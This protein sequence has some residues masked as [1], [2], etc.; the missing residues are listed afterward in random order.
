MIVDRIETLEAFD[1]IRDAYEDVYARD[2]HRNVFLSWAWLRAFM[3][4][5]RL[6]WTMLCVRRGTSYVAFCLVVERGMRIGPARLYRELALGAYPTA[7]YCGVLVG[8][9]EEAAICALATAIDDLRWNL[10]R[11]ADV[12]DPRVKRLI[13]LLG[14]GNAISTPAPT[15]A[16][17]VPLP[18]TWHEYVERGRSSRQSLRYVLRRYRQWQDAGFV[19]SDDRTIDRDIETLLELNHRRWK[20]NLRK[21]RK[22]YGRLFREAYANG[23]CTVAV[24]RAG[25]RPIAAQAAFVD[26]EQ[27]SW[28]V[29][30]LACDRNAPRNSPG[31]GM[32]A[33][34][35]ERA[36]ERRF[37]EY[38]FLRGSEAFKSQFGAQ[39]R[40]LDNYVVRRRTF[41]S[42]VGEFLYTFALQAKSRV[43]ALVVGGVA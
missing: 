4:A 21:A 6:P 41:W 39:V 8:D 3:L 16:S 5:M 13:T 34:A 29:Y 14:K 23:C 22:T 31:I 2:P 20:T 25:D 24:M 7:D 32:L 38:D 30:M 26:A 10:F 28:G 42:G 15:P 36:I 17:F 19:E 11:A 18:G 43:R 37:G 40:W 9:E 1:R 35:L 27:R 33:K 12:R